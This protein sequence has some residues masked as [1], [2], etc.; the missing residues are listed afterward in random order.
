[1]IYKESF[2]LPFYERAFFRLIE[3]ITS[4]LQLNCVDETSGMV[5]I[6]FSL[7]FPQFFFCSPFFF[8]LVC[9]CNGHA[10]RCRF[11]MELYKLSGRVS[12]GVCLKCRHFTTGRHCHYCKEGY[13]K[14]P[15]KAL[16]HRKMCKRKY[17]TVHWSNAVL[18]QQWISFF[19]HA[20]VIQS[21]HRAKHATIHRVNA[22]ARMASPG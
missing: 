22:H 19:Q 13:Y 6:G 7:I 10:R 15:T 4:N 2:N 16:N 14:D 17:P 3:R 12:G 5:F 1:M 9:N 11:N 18:L 21:V 20:I 8:Q